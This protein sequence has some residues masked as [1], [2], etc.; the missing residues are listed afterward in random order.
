MK[1]LICC[2][3]IEQYII[4]GREK[5]YHHRY[6]SLS[7]SLLLVYLVGQGLLRPLALVAPRVLRDC[8]RVGVKADHVHVIVKG[9][10]RAHRPIFQP[11][12]N[13]QQGSKRNENDHDEGRTG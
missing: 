11:G 1:R 6:C 4:D 12:N 13:E 9:S 2:C 3:V 5:C 8:L 10:F 7:L